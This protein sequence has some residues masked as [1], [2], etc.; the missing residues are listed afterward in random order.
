M[1]HHQPNN[2]TS[3]GAVKSPALIY[4]TDVYG[5]RIRVA[6]SDLDNPLKNLLPVYNQFGTRLC[7]SRRYN[8]KKDGGAAFL[9]RKNITGGRA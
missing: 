6:R 9:H 5:N 4:V 8:P 2:Q 1:P 7:D 3:A